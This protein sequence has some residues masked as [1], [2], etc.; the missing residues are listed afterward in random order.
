MG[1]QGSPIGCSRIMGGAAE[2]SDMLREQLGCCSF[3]D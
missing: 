3:N 1:A 2:V